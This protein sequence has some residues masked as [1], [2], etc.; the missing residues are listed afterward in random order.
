MRHGADPFHVQ[1]SRKTLDTFRINAVHLAQQKMSRTAVGLTRQSI[2]L[3]KMDTRV[4]PAY[5]EPLKI[6]KKKIRKQK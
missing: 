2:A 6:A 1:L 3:R 4:K 5:D